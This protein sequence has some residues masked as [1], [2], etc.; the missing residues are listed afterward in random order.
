MMGKGD[1]QLSFTSLEYLS[2]WEGRPVVPH[3]SIYAALGRDQ[4]IFRDELFAGIYGSTGHPSKSPSLLAK[5]LVLQFLE[6]VSDREAEA[7]A[8]YDLR[9]KAALGIE[10]GTSGF[11]ATTLSKF[12]TRLL[13]FQQE[14]VVF[15]RI[16]EVAVEKGLL[17]QK[18]VTQ[19]MDSTF[20]LGAASVQ[21][22]Y[23]LIRSATRKLINALRAKID[24]QL[25]AQLKLDYQERKKPAIDWSD[26]GA[27]EAHLNDLVSDAM[28]VL[29]ASAALPLTETERKLRAILERV[30][31]QDIEPKTDGDG[32]QI[33]K[34]VAEDRVIST[35]DPDMRHGR[36]SAS[37]TFNGYKTHI[38]MDQD[39]EFIS[40]VEVS[41]A[42]IHDGEVATDLLD[43]QPSEDLPESIMGD[44]C[45]GAGDVR[46]EMEKRGVLVKAPVPDPP[47][48]K[49]HFK[50]TDF[51]ID[52]EARTCRCPA[53][54]F[55]T[56]VQYDHKTRVLT[57]FHF[58]TQQCQTC[59]FASQ[60][61]SNK[62]GYRS[63]QV[64][65]NERLLQEGRR[66]QETAEFK[67][68]YRQ[69]RP[70]VERKQA[71]MVRHGARKAR[72]FGIVKVRLQMLFVTAAVNYKRLIHKLS[73]KVREAAKNLAPTQGG[74]VSA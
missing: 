26:K 32:Y 41:G 74:S 8:R 72:Y 54:Q 15:E 25:L 71:E 46:E 64:H 60:C 69:H 30:T 20:T 4:E 59:P 10:L 33:K 24:P 16:L 47:N 51:E 62:K 61:F 35:V 73:E 42:N 27:R 53:G 56:K 36:K 55:A 65:A 17:A 39:S 2:S 18:Q 6:N 37:R 12:R 49:G 29:K 66:Q 58:S 5:V 14:R 13:L 50:K 48:P 19:I 22:T 3:D 28:Q 63:V 38:A 31:F 9:W 11:D 21:N 43:Q 67:Q 70:A 68:E 52:L 34:G 40:A 7:R 57:G 1:P 44:H 45:Y 23:A